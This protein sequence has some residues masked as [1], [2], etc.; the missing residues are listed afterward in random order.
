MTPY[1]KCTRRGTQG[2]AVIWAHRD[3]ESAC[4]NT[5]FF[6]TFNQRSNAPSVD[7]ESYPTLE[8]AKQY[9][10]AWLRD[11]PAR[12][13]P[14]GF[15]FVNANPRSIDGESNDCVVRALSLAFN[16]PYTEVHAVCQRAG[17]VKGRGMNVPMINKAIAELTGQP[18]AQLQRMQRAQTFTTFARDH[19]VGNYVVIKHGHAIALI[20]GVFHDAGSVG[21][22]RA[23]VKSVFRVK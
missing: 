21:Q 7:A 19:K 1:V 8:W 22:P 17:R 9:A 10:H 23:I 2:Y 4:A 16:K 6:V 18:D 3:Y 5:R 15:E 20:D 12:A 14:Q 11:Q 13:K